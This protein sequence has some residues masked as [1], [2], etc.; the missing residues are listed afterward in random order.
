MIYIFSGGSSAEDEKPAEGGP[1]SN[2]SGSIIE[3]KQTHRFK[4]L[5]KRGSSSGFAP[6]IPENEENESPCERK[7]NN[8]NCC[9]CY[10]EDPSVFRR[11]FS[12]KISTP[13]GAG[14]EEGRASYSSSSRRR[15]NKRKQQQLNGTESSA[16][17]YGHT[18]TESKDDNES[19]ESHRSSTVMT[20]FKQ[21]ENPVHK[22]KY[23]QTNPSS[24]YSANTPTL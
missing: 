23:T 15:S 6:H 13:E 18:T 12:L 22:S 1:R 24:T 9:C 3:N 16:L 21:P 19:L 10:C 7:G 4:R 17:H 11:Q 8:R 14:K 20:W 2:S 5:R